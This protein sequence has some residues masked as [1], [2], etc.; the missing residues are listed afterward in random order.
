MERYLLRIC[1]FVAA[2]VI[3]GNTTLFA[4]SDLSAPPQGAPV[5]A[6]EYTP[7]DKFDE[8][9]SRLIG[10]VE[11]LGT[12]LEKAANKD[13]SSENLQREKDDLAAQQD[14]A[15]WAFWMTLAAA[16][17]AVVGIAGIYY[18]R[19]TLKINREA[20]RAAADAAIAAQKTVKAT[21]D[22]ERAHMVLTK[23]NLIV[24]AANKLYAGT[25]GT[26]KNSI[27]VSYAFKNFGRTPA[28]VR[29]TSVGVCYGGSPTILEKIENRQNIDNEIVVGAAEQYPIEVFR[30]FLA[31]TIPPD[32][33]KLLEANQ[34][35][36]FLVGSIIYSDIFGGHFERRFC[37]QFFGI[38]AAYRTWNK[39]GFHFERS[40]TID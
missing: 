32:E 29:K 10:A 35:S 12:A 40:L 26:D 15:R 23:P 39:D 17:Q 36:I 19:R 37:L 33:Y 4:N 8:F 18:L 6:T 27:S 14:M 5:K 25:M 11:N 28:F 34:I 16:A 21:Q 22:S 2:V 7:A 3:W 24:G 9:A 1:F 20:T 31:K 13:D 30:L 38:H